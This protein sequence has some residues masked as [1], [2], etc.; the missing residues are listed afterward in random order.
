[1]PTSAPVWGINTPHHWTPH[2]GITADGEDGDQVGGG[3][4]V[5]A[6]GSVA[7]RDGV[8]DGVGRHRQER[9]AR[10][11]VAVVLAG[12]AAI[13]QVLFFIFLVVFVVMLVLALV[14][15]HGH[16]AHHT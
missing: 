9:G 13:A 16:H 6:A 2:P 14:R 1:M 12:A 10:R 11:L 7:A 4:E 15:R 3:V 8:D 5:A